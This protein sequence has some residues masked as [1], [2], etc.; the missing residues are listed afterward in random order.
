MIYLITVTFT[1]YRGFAKVFKTEDKARKEFNHLRKYYENLGYNFRDW[2][3]NSLISEIET[4]TA[5]AVDG[6][7]C[8]ISLQKHN[9]E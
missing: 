4:I 9:P 6:Q 1:S 5:K 2:T 8:T 7:S 3:C